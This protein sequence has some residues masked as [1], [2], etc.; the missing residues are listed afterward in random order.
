MQP[1][2]CIINTLKEHNMTSTELATLLG[3]SQSGISDILNSRMELTADMI[4]E[5]AK[6]FGVD[7]RI[8]S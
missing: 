1:V 5:I 8:F 2:I 7:P 3:V 4:L 6:K